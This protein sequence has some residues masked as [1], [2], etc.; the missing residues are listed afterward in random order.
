MKQLIVVFKVDHVIDEEENRGHCVSWCPSE[1]HKK[2][3]LPKAFGARGWD[4]QEEPS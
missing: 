1:D 3:E 4:K 2:E